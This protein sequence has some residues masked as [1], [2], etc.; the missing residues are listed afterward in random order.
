[1]FHIVFLVLL[2][3]ISDAHASIIDDHDLSFYVYKAKNKRLHEHST[4]QKLLAYEQ[5]W[6]GK[7]VRSAIHSDSFFNAPTGYKDPEAEL[8][9]TL[10]AI[11]RLEESNP[12]LHAQCRFP[13]RYLWLKDQLDFSEKD[14]PSVNC[15]EFNEWSMKGKV[16]SLSI[17]FATGFLGNPASYYGHTL[18]KLNNKS[19]NN[20][21]LLDVSV[22]YGAIVPDGEDPITYIVK[23]LLGGYDAGFSH[24]EYYFHNH[25]Y[26]EIELR[27]LW[28]YELNLSSNDVRMILA[29]TWEV[30]GKEYTYYFLNKN[31]A[32]RMG[33]LFEIIDGIK[34]NPDTRF[35]VI[36]QAQI[37]QLG[38]SEYKGEPLIRDIQFHPS[39]Q[40][41]LY[42]RF[43]LLS[44]QEQTVVKQ[45]V[46]EISILEEPV[47][48]ELPDGSRYQIL[49]TLIDYYQFRETLS[50]DSGKEQQ[51]YQKALYKRY[52]LP[53]KTPSALNNY[54]SPPHTGRPPSYVQ[55]GIASHKQYGNG[56]SLT[57]RPAY[58]DALDSGSEHV[59]YGE[60]IM[61]QF[62]VESYSGLSRISAID[63]VSIQSLNTDV[64]G[65]PEDSNSAWRLKAGL[66]SA[67]MTCLSQC[68]AAR[69]EGDKG[70]VLKLN[71]Q[72]IAGVH[73]GGALMDNR[74][75]TG[76]V[77][78]R[79]TSHG[80]FD[81]T[82]NFRVKVEHQ[83]KRLMHAGRSL[84]DTQ[85][86]AR[87][88]FSKNKDIRISYQSSDS[89]RFL[90]ALGYYW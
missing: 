25:S 40:S 84:N 28:E 81:V 60:L 5:Q 44:H 16:D 20:N 13:A 55:A 26:G 70:Y 62:S 39:R 27:D 89:S 45:A 49:D 37:L 4:W 88:W 24:T 61:G 79:V 31:C 33:E 46:D 3:L 75:G 69:I 22:N 8:L 85:L 68:L 29:H 48:D 83:H 78:L 77:E 21:R 58:Y 10:K 43:S 34:V 74:F 18:L 72:L 47:F 12:N 57:V 52:Q 15:P 53:P 6:S 36:P 87:Y 35:W 54:P 23:G 86:D 59:E 66:Q 1:M 2:V 73:L 90:L 41:R 42:E 56:F 71:R 64:T 67:S 38:Q 14:I 65:L 82:E 19:S 11:A 63:F 17:V 50:D 32:Y 51:Q 30:M 7:N 80:I 76:N 9:A